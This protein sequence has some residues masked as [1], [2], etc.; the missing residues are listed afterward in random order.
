MIS[1]VT[2]SLDQGAYLE[3]AMES[4]LSQDAAVE[5]VVVDGGSTDGSKQ[6]IERHAERLAAWCSEP[7]GGQYAAINK[8]FAL[9]SGDVMAW[10]NADDF[11]L[12]GALALV[13]TVFRDHPEIEWLTG[14]LPAFANQHGHL[15]RTLGVHHLSRR[16]FDRGYNLPR[17]GHHS[18]YFIPQECV[19]WRRSLWERAGGRL[20]ES[21]HLAGD[22]ELWSRFY[23]H[24]ELWGVRALTGCFRLQPAQKTASH[25]PAYLE[26]GS[27]VMEALSLRPYSA[28]ESRIRGRL[29]R[30]LN[31]RLHR[32]PTAARDALE[33]R[34]LVYRGRELV[35]VDGA[36]RV[37]NTYFV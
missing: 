16:A 9:T 36:W 5:Y 25:L 19:F 2:P 1:I 15:Y 32:L 10:I 33:A 24:A 27:A 30:R 13:E 3:S 28:R 18:G 14:T 37:G 12:P 17:P 7:D 29:A 31:R 26:E 11:Y 34:G 4:V 23:R 21:L 35:W 6:I 20:D 8:G 22:F